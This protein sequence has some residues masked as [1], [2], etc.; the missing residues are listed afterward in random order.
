MVLDGGGGL[1]FDE[2]MGMAVSSQDV[3]GHPNPIVKERGLEDGRWILGHGVG[4]GLRP[5]L[6]LV[7]WQVDQDPAWKL[8]PGDIPDPSTFVLCEPRSLVGRKLRGIR[9][10]GCP[11]QELVTLKAGNE[12]RF[13][14][15]VVWHR[16]NLT[17][18]RVP[19]GGLGG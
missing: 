9:L 13:G 2:R 6:H 17:E 19:R 5:L 12:S 8:S 11:P 18:I 4:R 10:V 7:V 1:H 14:E 3:H 15:N 16:L